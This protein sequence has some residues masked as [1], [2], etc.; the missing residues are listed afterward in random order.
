MAENIPYH[1]S[2]LKKYNLSIK[3]LRMGVLCGE[4]SSYTMERRRDH[5]C[6]KTCGVK[7]KEAHLEVL[8]DFQILFGSVV[9]SAEFK[10]FSGIRSDYQAK[11]ILIE[12]SVKIIGKTKDR[13]YVLKPLF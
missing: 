12:N 2:L 5:W 3:D 6:C 10:R 13:K 1:V 11:T 7:S 4:C 9:T 8:R